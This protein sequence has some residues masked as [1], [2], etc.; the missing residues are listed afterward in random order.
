MRVFRQ[1]AGGQLH[2]LSEFT[3]VQCT[4]DLLDETGF[5]LV[6]D[7]LVAP[8]HELADF[9]I[10]PGILGINLAQGIPLADGLC[11]RALFF[12]VPRFGHDGKHQVAT[13]AR[14]LQRLLKLLFVG[15]ALTC[16]FENIDF[17]IQVRLFINPAGNLGDIR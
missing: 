16:R 11:E 17:A 13:F 5:G 2:G 10:D 8:L 4:V 3:G 6:L 12:V 1:S 7:L 14:E 9:N 15:E